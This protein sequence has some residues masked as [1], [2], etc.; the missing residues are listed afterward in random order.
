MYFETTVWIPQTI[1]TMSWRQLPLL[2]LSRSSRTE[3]IKKPPV[4]TAS[5]LA[6]KNL[7]T[8]TLR[9]LVSVVSGELALCP[10]TTTWKLTEVMTVSKAEKDPH[11]SVNYRLITVLLI[12]SKIIEEIIVTC[13]RDEMAE[14][15]LIPEEQFGFRDNY[16]STEFQLLLVADAIRYELSKRET[17]RV[18]YLDL[19]R[20]FDTI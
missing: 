4:R 1:E 13:L 17:T 7:S 16:F 6:L 3:R 12:L 10:F 9:C 2:S 8:R 20:V 18:V 14:I 15:A 11:H 5:E 19:I